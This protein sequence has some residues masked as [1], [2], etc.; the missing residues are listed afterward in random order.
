MKSDAP[1]QYITAKRKC[2]NAL[3]VL[4]MLV[5]VG[6]VL[7]LVPDEEARVSI[8]VMLPRYDTTSPDEPWPCDFEN[9]VEGEW[10]KV[11]NPTSHGMLF[12]WKSCDSNESCT[13][14]IPWYKHAGPR[15]Q[16]LTDYGTW[17][18]KNGFPI[19]KPSRCTVTPPTP[20]YIIDIMKHRKL[21]IIGDSLSAD[22]YRHLLYTMAEKTNLT[23]NNLY[24][25]EGFLPGIAVHKNENLFASNCAML[26]KHSTACCI[27]IKQLE[28]A[29][30]HPAAAYRFVKEK[31][32]IG[33]DD[34]VLV[35]F[36]LHYYKA[37]PTL[38]ETV[39][40]LLGE[41]SVKD[42]ETPTILFREMSPQ[43]HVGGRYK[44][45][46]HCCK[47]PSAENGVEDWG[48][49]VLGS[50]LERARVPLLKMFNSTVQQNATDM[51]H[52]RCLDPSEPLR[53]CHVRDKQ[54]VTP[55]GVHFLVAGHTY[56]H[57]N[58]V[59]FHHLRV[60]L[61]PLQN[62]PRDMAVELKGMAVNLT[63]ADQY[64]VYNFSVDATRMK[65]PP[66]KRKKKFIRGKWRKV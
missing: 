30:M 9:E 17:V 48:N 47:R 61:K 24:Q 46:M 12:P 56:H 35:N 26:G 63:H 29:S 60:L 31:L 62:P 43:F 6:S 41:M 2:H 27:E 10:V 57:W 19:F 37:S 51:K 54:F 65:D 22:H 5:C 45:N 53:P 64:V 33:K 1:D 66:P 40:D 14:A 44:E 4:M 39:E 15:R 8:P 16:R 32:N 18:K 38:E 28:A 55:D 11:Q 21:I 20:S 25:T 34:I 52:G 58:T 50:V 23:N 49:P 7:F 3:P 36:G 42:N 59:L 13:R